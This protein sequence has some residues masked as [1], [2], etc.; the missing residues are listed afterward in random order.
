MSKNNFTLNEDL[1]FSFW[2]PAEI[3]KAV[4]ADPKT[5]YDNMILKGI[6]STDDVD[7]DDQI[8][9]N[10][11]FDISYLLNNGF[12]NWHHQSKN[13]PS[14]IIGEPIDGK[15]LKEGLFIKAKLYNTETAREAYD[16]A[17]VL[18]KQSKTRRLGWSIEGKPIEKEG[19]TITKARITGVALTHAPKNKHT[20][21]E[22]CKAMTEGTLTEDFIKENNNGGGNFVFETQSATIT[23]DKRGNLHYIEKALSTEV[24][25]GKV[26]SRESLEGGLKLKSNIFDLTMQR[27][28]KKYPDITFAKA[29]EVCNKVTK[30]K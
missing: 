26:L 13:N 9:K 3:E 4:N 17:E 28:F 29:L 30:S 21:A 16:L 2:F 27:V 5:K 23:F 11:G 25:S 15:L 7:L 1:S 19:N 24:G 18:E 10:D 20:F 22:L 6:A 14:A 12:V 8:M